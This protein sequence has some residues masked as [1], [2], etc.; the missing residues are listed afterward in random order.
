MFKCLFSNYIEFY[1]RDSS[2][3]QW[4]VRDDWHKS[5]FRVEHMS[6]YIRIVSLFKEGGMFL[7]LDIVT[8][9]PYDGHLFRSLRANRKQFKR[10]NNECCDAI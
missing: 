6:D 9:K 1:L 4:Y 8:M 3:E 5:P 2:L 10:S 7:D